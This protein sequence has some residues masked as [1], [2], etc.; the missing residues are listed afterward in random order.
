MTRPL[1]PRQLFLVFSHLSLLGFGGVLPWAYRI[2]VERR[3][4]ITPDTFRE[5]FAYA[6]LF[7]GPTICN[8]AVLVGHRESGTRG[9][10]AAL[11]GMLAVPC[12]LVCSLW[13]LLQRFGQTPLVADALRGMSAV[14]AG[15]VVATACKLARTLPRDW[16]NLVCAALVVLGLALFRLPL[17]LLIVV[18]IP[19]ALLLMRSAPATGVQQAPH[20][21]G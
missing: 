17:L 14:A 16:R 12:V 8:M 5:L 9:G 10:L 13:Y 20:G 1:T 4:L 21:P 2:L 18:M 3:Q 7:P 6:Q 19:A 11:A 15:L